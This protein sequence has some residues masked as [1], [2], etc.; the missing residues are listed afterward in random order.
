MFLKNYG[1]HIIIIWPMIYLL[2]DYYFLT[3]EIFYFGRCLPWAIIDRIPY[4]RK[5]KIQDEKIPSDKEQW[6]CLKSVL[7][8]HFL[9]EAFPIWFFHPLCQKL[10]LVIKYHSL[11][12]LIC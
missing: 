4:F 10:V 2:L 12:L 9:V 6:E 5:W 11:K 8:S 3:H 1:G 7:T